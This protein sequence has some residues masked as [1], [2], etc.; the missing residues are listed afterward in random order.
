MLLICDNE[1]QLV[2][3]IQQLT[4]YVINNSGI[5]KYY[6]YQEGKKNHKFIVFR[7]KNIFSIEYNI[8]FTCVISS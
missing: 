7:K 8:M 3:R 6:D 4:S 1:T 5:F 2:K